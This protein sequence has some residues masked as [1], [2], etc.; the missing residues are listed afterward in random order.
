M[1]SACTCMPMLRARAMIT[2]T[3]AMSSSSSGN[4]ATKPWSIFSFCTGKRFSRSSDE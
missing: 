3:I 1:P 4:P 2:R